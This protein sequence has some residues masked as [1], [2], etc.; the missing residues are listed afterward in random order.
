MKHATLTS[1]DGDGSDQH[2]QT[3]DDDNQA[4]GGET[5]DDLAVGNLPP[6][7]TRLTPVHLKANDVI[8]CNQMTSLVARQTRA[9]SGTHIPELYY[10]SGTRSLRP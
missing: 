4:T 8:T 10:T 9:M 2:A 1:Q 7:Q 5:D 3:S 6:L